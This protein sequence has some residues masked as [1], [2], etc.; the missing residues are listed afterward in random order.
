[1]QDTRLDRLCF[2]CGPIGGLA[3]AGGD[4]GPERAEE[5]AVAAV[6]AAWECGLRSF[7]TAPSY[8]DGAAERLL[9]TALRGLP[10]DRF[11]VSGKV[12]R[13]TMA[14]ADPYRLD[15][16]AA[17]REPRFDFTAAV[18]RRTVETSLERL[19]FDRLDT[20]FLHDPDDLLGP[21]L[22]EA[23]PALRD[24]RRAGAVG[25]IGVGT[26]RPR[27]AE[28][29]VAAGAVDT[30]MIA[31]EW[32]LLR[33]SAATLLARCHEAGVPV[34]AAA[35]YASG[36]LAVARPGPGLPYLYRAPSPWLLEAA[37]RMADCCRR[38]GAEL[39]QA[40]IQFP[41]RHPAVTQVVVGMRDAGEVVA[42]AA[43]FT[44][45]LPEA[46]WAELDTLWAGLGTPPGEPVPT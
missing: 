34:L 30:V 37:G 31:G 4:T 32:N 18:V 19:G 3:A 6:E 1:M 13:R 15:G 26:T 2:G 12:G 14:I 21:A 27:A 24:L 42:N 11:T 25:A 22:D 44:T 10:R 20:V 17:R 5:I 43:R 39:P 29:L 9:G 33:R 46:L 7:D 40:A 45:D 28:A 8:G 36:L 23:V 38:H 16:A 35:P 41:L